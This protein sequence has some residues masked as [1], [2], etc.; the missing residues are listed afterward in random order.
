MGTAA[1]KD[2]LAQGDLLSAEAQAAGAD[3]LD[4]RRA[5]RR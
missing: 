4:H 2:V 5:R 3:D 1:N